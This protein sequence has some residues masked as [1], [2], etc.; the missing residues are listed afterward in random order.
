MFIWGSVQPGHE[1]KLSPSKEDALDTC[2]YVNI[3][4]YASEAGAAASEYGS[5]ALTFAWR[6]Y[7]A[8]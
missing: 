8:L 4:V 3:G 1:Y 5:P 2:N 6:F 7:H